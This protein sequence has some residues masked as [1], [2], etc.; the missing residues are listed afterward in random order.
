[1][2]DQTTLMEY[3]LTGQSLSPSFSTVDVAIDVQNYDLIV[4]QD[5]NNF[6][7]ILFKL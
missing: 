1:M 7:V 4:L 3:P 2:L 6:R 5:F